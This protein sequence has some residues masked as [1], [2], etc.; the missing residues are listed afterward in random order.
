MYDQNGDLVYGRLATDQTQRIGIGFLYAFDFGL[1][2]G[3]FQTAASGTPI[4]TIGMSPQSI[5][6]YPYGIGDLGDTPWITSTS[7]TLSQRFTLG[8]FALSIG[9]TVLNLFDE[10]TPTRMWTHRQDED[11]LI[12]Q[13]DFIAGFDYE[14]ELAA[15]DETDLDPRF[16][17]WDT[18]QSAREIRVTLKLE[19]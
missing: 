3:G 17:F 13:E 2:V 6:F 10:D 7:L 9:A 18:Y 1:S 16:G 14:E 5:F 19:F 4:S 12:S 11:L 8:K 15:L